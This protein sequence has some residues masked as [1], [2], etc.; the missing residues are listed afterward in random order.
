M[1]SVI[2]M[3]TR[4]AKPAALHLVC[5]YIIDRYCSHADRA[6]GKPGQT[7]RQ[8][9]DM[10]IFLTLENLRNRSD[11]VRFCFQTQFMC[12]GQG[13][14]PATFQTLHSALQQAVS[15]GWLLPTAPGQGRLCYTLTVGGKTLLGKA[16]S[17]ATPL[18]RADYN[19]ERALNFPELARLLELSIADYIDK[20]PGELRQAIYLR[21]REMRDSPPVPYFSFHP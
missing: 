17:D 20:P 7:T 2:S 16:L 11:G 9:C 1:G 10:L 6:K 14:D 5:M 4:N 12:A 19:A 3:G 13:G 18:P 8:A 21:S 15:F